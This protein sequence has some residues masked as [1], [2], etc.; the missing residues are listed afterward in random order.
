[1]YKN[2]KTKDQYKVVEKNKNIIQGWTYWFGDSW[3]Q[4][5]WPNYDLSISF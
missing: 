3:L 1:M 5:S 2:L 4:C